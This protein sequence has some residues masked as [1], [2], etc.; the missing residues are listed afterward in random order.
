[1]EQVKQVNTDQVLKYIRTVLFIVG[2]WRP[3]ESPK[4]F[5]IIYD[6]IGIIFLYVFSIHFAMTLLVNLFSNLQ[7][8]ELTTRIYITVLQTALAFKAVSLFIN[9][10][11]CQQIGK[12]LNKFTTHSIEEEQLVQE[13]MKPFLKYMFL[14]WFFPLFAITLWH[15]NV[16]L[17]GSTKVVFDSWNPGLDWKHNRYDFWT[18]YAYQYISLIISASINVMSDVYYSFAMY[19]NSIQLEI[20]GNRLKNIQRIDKTSIKTMRETLIGHSETYRKTMDSIDSLGKDLKWTYF[21]QV[22]SS[23]IIICCCTNEVARVSFIN[24]FYNDFS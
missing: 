24:L 7:S 11:S 15:L 5:R 13:K 16:L 8:P 6:I 1:M 20:L 18:V 14:C 4:T 9:N 2:L 23:S 3:Y 17:M 22:I 21:C 12:F 10:A 19:M